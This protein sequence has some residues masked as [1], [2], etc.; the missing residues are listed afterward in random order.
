MTLTKIIDHYPKQFFT[1]QETI[2]KDKELQK[3]IMAYY[4][5]MP[6]VDCINRN[7]E[8]LI[9]NVFGY[10]KGFGSPEVAVLDFAAGTGIFICDA[11]GRAFKSSSDEKD[12]QSRFHAIEIDKSSYD[13]CIKNIESVFK[14]NGHGFTPDNIHNLNTLTQEGCDVC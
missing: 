12:I 5:P 10:E 3:N 8:N 7:V 1:H 11:I 2:V 9:I 14:K 6:I 13:I 4:T